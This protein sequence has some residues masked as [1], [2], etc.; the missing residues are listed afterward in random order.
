MESLKNIY[1]LRIYIQATGDELYTRQCKKAIARQLYSLP[2]TCA[3]NIQS[4]WDNAHVVWKVK[5]NWQLKKSC[6]LK[7]ISTVPGM[8]DICVKS[9]FLTF[10]YKVLGRNLWDIHPFSFKIKERELANG[11]RGD[12]DDFL[13]SNDRWIVKPKSGSGGEGIRIMSS[14]ALERGSQEHSQ[15]HSSQRS[16]IKKRRP[17]D[18]DDEYVIQKYITNPMLCN[19]RKF[20]LRVLLLVTPEGI[21]VHKCIYARICPSLYQNRDFANQQVHL[22]N[23]NLRQHERNQRQLNSSETRSKKCHTNNLCNVSLLQELPELSYLQPEVICFCEQKL[24]P[25]FKNILHTIQ[26]HN[27]PYRQFQLFGIDILVD[28]NEHLWL[29]EINGDPGRKGAGATVHADCMTR[30]TFGV[31]PIPLSKDDDLIQLGKE[32]N[33]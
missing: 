6:F 2:V 22:T 4:T 1:V 33:S 9:H 28:D 32:R 11:L 25:I 31:S 19:G 13:R 16:L 27:A 23:L 18:S 26:L 10:G 12:Y 30:G 20:D 21:F 14:S 24:C 3:F 8:S 7:V 17:S 5:P 15:A 29:L